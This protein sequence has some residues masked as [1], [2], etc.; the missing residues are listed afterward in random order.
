MQGPESSSRFINEQTEGSPGKQPRHQLRLPNL[1]ATHEPPGT[2]SFSLHRDE[3]IPGVHD[4]TWH[5]PNIQWM[6]T[7]TVVTMDNLESFP[8]NQAFRTVMNWISGVFLETH[9]NPF[10]NH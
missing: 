1:L 4:S 5:F 3:T 6:K 9:P 10:L 2:P 7:A 8:I